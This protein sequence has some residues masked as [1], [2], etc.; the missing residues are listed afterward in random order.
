MKAS[1]DDGSALPSPRLRHL[2]SEKMSDGGRGVVDANE[3]NIALQTRAEDDP[4]NAEI[5]IDPRGH[6]CVHPKWH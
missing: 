6:G 2:K 4:W 1:L 5:A 3:F